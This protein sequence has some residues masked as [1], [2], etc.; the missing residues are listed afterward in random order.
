MGVGV[1]RVRREHGMDGREAGT[2]IGIYLP[3]PNLLFLPCPRPHPLPP[4]R[5]P[6]LHPHAPLAK[7]VQD[8]AHTRPCKIVRDLYDKWTLL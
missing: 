2:D 4:P 6:P 3:Q 7:S 8:Q 5:P 1:G